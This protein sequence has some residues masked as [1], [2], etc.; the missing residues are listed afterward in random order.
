MI[1]TGTPATFVVLFNELTVPWVLWSILCRRRLCLVAVPPLV[2]RL[3]AGLERLAQGLIARGWAV[4]LEEFDPDLEIYRHAKIPRH[5]HD[6]FATVEPWVEQRF[7]FTAATVL[8]EDSMPVRQMVS[9]MVHEYFNILFFVH[10]LAANAVQRGTILVMADPVLPGLY[11]ALYGEDIAAPVRHLPELRWG[12][13]LLMA[14]LMIVGAM[15]TVLTSIRLRPTAPRRVFL[16]SDYANDPRDRLL[17]DETTAK[18]RDVLV[19]FRNAAQARTAGATLGY[20]WIVWGTGAFSPAEGIAALVR[21]G[22]RAVRLI[23]FAWAL[24]SQA[25]FRV[26]ALPAKRVMTERMMARHRFDFFWGRDEYNVDHILRNQW[27]RRLGGISLGASHGLPIAAI[28]LPMW[29]YIDCDIFYVIGT[30]L[31]EYYAATWAP[32]MQIRAVGS[33]GLEA[34]HLARLD[35]PRPLDII[36]SAKPGRLVD[37]QADFAAQV[38]DAFPDRTILLQ[39]KKGFAETD[40]GRR[41]LERVAVGRPQVQVTDKRIYDLFF[42]ARYLITD[43]STI[44]AEAIQFG[45]ASFIL[46]IDE[47]K[48]MI[49]RDFPDLCVHSADDV[50]DRIRAIEDGT[51]TYPRSRF[52]PLVALSRQPLITAIHRDMGLTEA[53]R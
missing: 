1:R 38:A 6:T 2:G 44:G 26:A 23:R 37:R 48:S 29:R 21:A 25:F 28:V 46:D 5:L 20:G 3:A 32:H 18:G 41:F 9:N 49:F 53:G 27:L 35:A 16:G 52:E 51:W 34:R 17:W 7:R 10:H 47:R 12:L 50:I 36:F 22:C 13:N 8:D 4:A 15:L 31:A 14:I 45:L 40:V 24:P 19:V 30:R 43:P 39:F 33:L 42:D 11:R